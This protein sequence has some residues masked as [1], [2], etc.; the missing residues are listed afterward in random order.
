MRTPPFPAML[1]H[2]S[3]M[4]VSCVNE[5]QILFPGN[6]HRQIPHLKIESHYWACMMLGS[7][8]PSLKFKFILTSAP[9]SL[10]CSFNASKSA[11]CFFLEQSDAQPVSRRRRTGRCICET[12]EEANLKPFCAETQAWECSPL[13]RSSPIKH[14]DF[15]HRS[16][17][18]PAL[19]PLL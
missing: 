19:H 10:K 17:L 7:L 12:P 9:I 5:S 18:Q 2:F 15:S 4:A 8:L 16:S 1:R 11:E 3:W 13:L 6:L 14:N